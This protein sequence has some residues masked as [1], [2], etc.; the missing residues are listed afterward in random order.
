MSVV[1]FVKF[2]EFRVV[3]PERIETVQS[4][5]LVFALDAKRVRLSILQYGPVEPL[6]AHASP[7][8]KLYWNPSPGAATTALPEEALTL[9]ITTSALARLEKAKNA[10]KP[11]R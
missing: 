11:K 9:V 8:V 6:P 5:V 3:E 10:V 2:W 1:A 7:V 4:P